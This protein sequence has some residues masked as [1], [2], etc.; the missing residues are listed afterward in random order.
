MN[1]YKVKIG[2]NVGIATIYYFR[3]VE[4]FTETEALDLAIEKVHAAEAR[5]NNKLCG[6]QGCKQNR[7][8]GTKCNSLFLSGYSVALIPN[9]CQHCN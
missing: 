5:S 3:T 9:E 4:A 2:E 1:Y 6:K 8:A 7:K